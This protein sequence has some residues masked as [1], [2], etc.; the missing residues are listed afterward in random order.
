[1]KVLILGDFEEGYKAQRI[2]QKKLPELELVGFVDRDKKK[3]KTEPYLVVDY[4]T[5]LVMLKRKLVD[6]IVIPSFYERNLFRD[7]LYKIG[8][9][10][11]DR[12]DVIVPPIDFFET[13]KAVTLDEFVIPWYKAKQID[14]I[15]FATTDACNLNCKRCARFAPIASHDFY[16]HEVVKQSFIRLKEFIKHINMIRILGGEPFLDEEVDDY[17]CFLRKLYP[18]AEIRIVTNGLLI[19]S[20]PARII[21]SI[22]DNDIGVDISFY[23]PLKSK[24]GL[25]EKFLFNRGIDYRVENG[26]V[27]YKSFDLKSTDNILQKKEYCEQWCISLKENHLYPCAT[28]ATVNYFKD[29]FHVELPV[30]E[31]LD[32]NERGLTTESIKEYIEKPIQLCRYCNFKKMELW[33]AA[34][35]ACRMEDW[36][37]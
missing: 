16:D 25:I 13:D 11:I 12:E 14:Y 32:L 19:E 2:I 28:S 7:I 23:P 20:M 5:M 24:L 18:F 1:M 3:R 31:G 15:E 35:N 36:I 27:F 22:I 37:V 4:K 29:E 17:F 8:F 33:E 21:N 34:G 9:L 10:D 26:E 6:R 30:N